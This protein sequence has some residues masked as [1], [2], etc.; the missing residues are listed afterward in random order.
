MA[1]VL[2]SNSSDQENDGF[3]GAV[4]FPTSLTLFAAIAAL[5]LSLLG[6]SG[7]LVTVIALIKDKKLR[8]KATTS[9]IIRHKD[10]WVV[11]L[12]VYASRTGWSDQLQE[13]LLATLLPIVWLCLIWCFVA[14][15]FHSLLSGILKLTLINSNCELYVVWTRGELIVPAASRLPRITDELKNVWKFTIN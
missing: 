3:S 7:N 13:H 5:V 4:H 10:K 9:F 6:V 15:I 12:E 8:K 11:R 14:S 2:P 1:S